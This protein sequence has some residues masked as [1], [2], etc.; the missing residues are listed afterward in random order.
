MQGIQFAFSTNWKSLVRSNWNT[1]G[2]ETRKPMKATIFAH[3]RTAR[4]VRRRESE[5]KHQE[6]D[7]GREQNDRENVI[8]MLVQSSLLS[9]YRVTQIG[10]DHAI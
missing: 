3:Q 8:H 9:Y 10:D 1:S 7:Q 4:A 6:A 5:Q 2:R